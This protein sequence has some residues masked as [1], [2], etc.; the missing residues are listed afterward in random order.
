SPPPPAWERSFPPPAW[1]R[2]FPPPAWER[3]FPPPAWER[4]L[5]AGGALGHFVVAMPDCAVTSLKSVVYFASATFFFAS[6]SGVHVMT[7]GGCGI[8]WTH[9]LSRI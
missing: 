8:V 2:S 6:W 7:L 1:E 3:S 9:C 5:P 4:S